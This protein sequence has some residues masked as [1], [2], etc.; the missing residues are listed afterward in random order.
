VE[1]SDEISWTEQ[2]WAA[3]DSEANATGK[4]RTRNFV[5]RIGGD[6]RR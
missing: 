5:M 3:S 4:T 6:E 2:G 1:R